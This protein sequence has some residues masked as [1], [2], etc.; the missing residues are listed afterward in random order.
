MLRLPTAFYQQRYA[1]DI[2]SR[3][4]GNS[5]VADLVSGP[6]ATTLVGLL[7]VVIYG[8][9][10][11]AFDPVLAAVGV[12]LGA[13]NMA[14]IAAVQRILA[15]ENIKVKHFGGMLAGSMMH[16][17][18]I[19]ETI[20]AG[21]SEHEALVRLTGNQAR[22]TNA[23]QRVT[24]VAGLL[25]VLPPLLSLVT[26]AA[27]LGLGGGHVIDGV[28]SVG[29]LVAFQTLLTQFNRPFGDLVGLGSSM[30][31]LQAEL[32]RLDDVEQHRIDPVFDP[33][34][35]APAAASLAAGPARREPPRRLSGRLELRDVTFGFNR[36]IDEPLIKRLSLTVRPG[37]RVALVGSSGS[38]K[39]TIGRLAAGLLRPWEGEILY[40]GFSIDEIPRDVFTDQVG[41]VDDQTLLFSGTIRENLTLWDEAVADRDVTR[42]AMDAGIHREIVRLRSGYSAR[43]SEGARNLSGGQRQRMEIGRALIRN[44]ALLILDEATSALD[45][46]TEA[47]VDD[48]LRRR[49]CTCL[50]IAH[51]LSTIRDCEEIIVLR[52]GKVIERGTHDELMAD[53]GGFYAQLQ[54]LGDG[55]SSSS[56]AA[57]VR[58]GRQTAVAVTATVSST[59]PEA[60]RSRTA[61]CSSPRPCRGSMTGSRRPRYRPWRSAIATMS[62]HRTRRPG[63]GAG[64]LWRGGHGRGQPA[65][66][67]DDPGAVWRVTSGQ[68]DVFYLRPRSGP[69]PRAA[70]SPLPRRGGGLD[71]RAGRGPQ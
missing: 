25:V 6:L 60:P 50:I 13:V 32:A 39:S 51:R 3:V 9:V 62:D 64:A 22:L 8:G 45:P 67:L 37:S 16:A 53:T 66:S 15:D 19:V 57:P 54:T 40:D 44:P 42:A 55:V 56:T 65:A 14:G 11:L 27:V 34:P 41:M 4:D 20:K 43:L 1:G 69:G 2:A 52:Q 58:S 71:L 38:G 46:V 63:R 70:T 7:M 33:L 47:L 48:N 26:T 12:V 21:A 29:A 30:Q 36:T 18:Q 10:M 61:T 17:V 31:T 24:T 23:S 28:M 5:A 59:V 35:R 49:G 68:V